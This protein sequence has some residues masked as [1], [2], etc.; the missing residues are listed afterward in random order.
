M[1]KVSGEDAYD[2]RIPVPGGLDQSLAGETHHNPEAAESK[3]EGI[4]GKGHRSLRVESAERIR[5]K[6]DNKD[7][8]D[9]QEGKAAMVRAKGS[10]FL[11][12]RRHSSKFEG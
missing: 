11:L 7:T 2:T 1:T 6:T 4:E 10:P 9:G 3:P 8:G 5:P 12:A